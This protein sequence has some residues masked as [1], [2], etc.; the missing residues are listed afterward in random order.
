MCRVTNTGLRTLLAVAVPVILSTASFGCS[1]EGRSETGYAGPSERLATG[2]TAISATGLVAAYDMERSEGGLILDRGPYGLHGKVRGH[3]VEEGVHGGAR[4]F[5]TVEDRVDLPE[6]H[7]FDLDGPLTIAAWVRVDSLG[8]HQHIAACDDKWALWVTP[9][10]Q[11]RLGDTRGGGW[12]TDEGRVESGRW[13]PVVAV[14]SGS[15]GDTL[16]PG[17]AALW[18]DGALASA[19][20]HLRSDSAQARGTWEPGDLYPS[21]A[22]SIGFESHQGNAAHQ[23]MP[24]VGAIDDLLVFA[25]A[26]SEQEV[27]AFSER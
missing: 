20:A 10:D 9:A 27:R 6:H 25:R 16:S 19:Y 4:R 18:V 2:S 21:D 15:R 23:L 24:F 3:R 12:S 26:W 13:T 1:V 14:L 7:A 11:F 8:L 5:T 17:T 22:C